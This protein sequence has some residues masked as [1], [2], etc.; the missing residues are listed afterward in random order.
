MYDTV[1]S[2]VFHF[3][4]QYFIHDLLYRSTS[5]NVCKKNFFKWTEKKI[6]R[7]KYDKSKF[8]QASYKESYKKNCTHQWTMF[9]SNQLD[10]SPSFSFFPKSSGEKYIWAMPPSVCNSF[11]VESFLNFQG[12]M[13]VINTSPTG[14]LAPGK[15]GVLSV[16]HLHKDIKIQQPAGSEIDFA[17]CFTCGFLHRTMPLFKRSLKKG[18][19]TILSTS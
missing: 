7:E 5:I 18:Q 15:A 12:T 16:T 2:N 9:E 19:L 14:A 3:I 13:S 1:S 11:M 10:C 4:L 8:L 6:S 17:G